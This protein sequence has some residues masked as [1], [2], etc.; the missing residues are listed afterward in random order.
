MHLP[1]HLPLLCPAFV[2]TTDVLFVL[3]QTRRLEGNR[4]KSNCGLFALLPTDIKY[5]SGF[6]W[7]GWRH[8][9]QKKRAD[10]RAA[11]CRGARSGCFRWRCF[12]RSLKHVVIMD[13]DRLESRGP[14]SWPSWLNGTSFPRKSSEVTFP[15]GASVSPRALSLPVPH[16]IQV[17]WEFHGGRLSKPFVKRFASE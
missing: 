16:G 9:Q 15:T 10:R 11:L 4:C 14:L 7:P 6:Q 5:I 3:F 12:H 2:M 13:S 1:S 8:S 17:S